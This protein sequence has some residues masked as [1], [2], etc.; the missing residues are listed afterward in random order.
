MK[1]FNFYYYIINISRDVYK[2]ILETCL[3]FFFFSLLVIVW[4]L[5]MAWSKS[6]N[7]LSR[8]LP[9]W[10][11]YSACDTCQSRCVNH[12]QTHVN[13]FIESSKYY[14]R[15]KSCLFYHK[16]SAFISHHVVI[17]YSIRLFI[18]YFYAY[19]ICKP[20]IWFGNRKNSI[21]FI[22]VWRHLNFS[23]SVIACFRFYLF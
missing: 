22:C 15:N 6:I 13:Q 4:S 23:I 12:H 19:L 8:L 18:N 2:I 20:L 21:K 17:K 7:A 10:L 11:S 16:T 14:I 9:L 5:R 3:S 1:S